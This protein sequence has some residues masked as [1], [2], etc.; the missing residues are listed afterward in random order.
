VIGAAGAV[1]ASTFGQLGDVEARSSFESPYTLTQTYNAALRLVRV[2]LGLTVTERDPSAAYILFDYK[3]S[4]SGRR[5]APGSIEMLDSGR[6]VKIVVQLGQMPRYHE[7]VMG[8]A[9]AKKLRDE[10]GE[11][12]PRGNQHEVIDAGVDSASP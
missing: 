4:E 6:A 3:S 1:L 8:D 9:L 10:Y 2:D 5:V 12:A 11:P 7:Q